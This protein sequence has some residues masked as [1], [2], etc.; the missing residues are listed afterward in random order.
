M[1]GTE[2]KTLQYAD[3]TTG[4]LTTLA[5]RNIFFQ[6]V[7]VFGAASTSRRN[8]SK[9]EGLAMGSYTTQLV[10]GQDSEEIKW[11]T[12]DQVVTPLGAPFS[13]T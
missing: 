5:H 6:A 12:G 3:D 8:L 4:L 11:A 7:D 10:Q 2:I 13:E 9:T 1:P